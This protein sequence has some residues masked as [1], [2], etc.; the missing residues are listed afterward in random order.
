MSEIKQQADIKPFVSDP[1]G[2][3]IVNN[4]QGFLFYF[5]VELILN[6]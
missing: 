5:G 4:Q 1:E 3:E 2:A 6:L